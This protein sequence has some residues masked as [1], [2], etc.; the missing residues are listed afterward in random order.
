M[1]QDLNYHP[2]SGYE[3]SQE[4]VMFG[5]ARL[6]TQEGK[7]VILTATEYRKIQHVFADRP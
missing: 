4:I 3:K 6:V 1:T 2:H 7:T 5:E